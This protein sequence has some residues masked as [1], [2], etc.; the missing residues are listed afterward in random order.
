MSTPDEIV[1]HA[2]P[3]PW[4][5]HNNGWRDWIEDATGNVVV[6]AV[7]H[8]DG[9]LIVACVNDAAACGTDMEAITEN[10]VRES[11]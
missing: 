9:P 7:G 5:Y 2:S 3:R 10:R 1:K 6:S 4:S 11:A 8:L